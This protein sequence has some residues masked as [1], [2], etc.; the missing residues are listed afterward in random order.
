MAGTV[1]G[2]QLLDFYQKTVL[3]YFD[4]V[5]IKTK[6]EKEPSQEVERPAIAAMEV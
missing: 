3:V 4:G 2:M 5:M 6:L 1:S